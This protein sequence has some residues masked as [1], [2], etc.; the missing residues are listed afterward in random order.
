MAATKGIQA[1]PLFKLGKAAAVR[2]KDTVAFVQS[3]CAAKALPTQFD[4]THPGNRFTKTI[5]SQAQLDALL[6]AV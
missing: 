2:D 3:L 4:T 6:P 1:H 5:I